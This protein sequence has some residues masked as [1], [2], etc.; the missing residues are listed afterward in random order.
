MPCLPRLG[1]TVTSTNFPADAEWTQASF[2]PTRNPVSSKCATSAPASAPV[3]AVVAGEMSPA[4]LRA[5]AASAPRD[6]PQLN[7]SPSAAAG[8][9]GKE[10]GRAPRPRLRAAYTRK[11]G[12]RHLF[13]ACELGEDKLYG[14]IK[15]RKTRARFLEFCRYLRSLHPSSARIA[16]ICDNFQPQGGGQHD[17]PVH[18]LAQQ[19][20]L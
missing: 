10:P 19:P 5:C 3:M 11:A 12:V 7:I 18:H 1:C 2:P 13:A 9:K 6:G 17:P 4:I 8:G 16:V 14:R 20:C 15:P